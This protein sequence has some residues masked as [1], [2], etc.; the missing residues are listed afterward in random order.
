MVCLHPVKVL[1]RPRVVTSVMSSLAASEKM[2]CGAPTTGSPSDEGLS[3]SL[4]QQNRLLKIILQNAA[5]MS[6]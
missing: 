2:Q 4:Q 3:S 6:N 1:F 5:T